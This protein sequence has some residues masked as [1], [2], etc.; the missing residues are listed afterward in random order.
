MNK[1]IR[2]YVGIRGKN[3]LTEEEKIVLMELARKQHSISASHILGSHPIK[4]NVDGAGTL[5][6]AVGRDDISIQKEQTR[7]F[8]NKLME[9]HQ[10]GA[11]S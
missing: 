10:K 6:I 3:N 4:M 1:S 2:K 8:I 11:F 5:R 9:W 7:S